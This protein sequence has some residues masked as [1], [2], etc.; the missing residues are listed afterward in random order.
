MHPRFIMT[1]L[2]AALAMTCNLAMAQE[3][4]GAKAP[5]FKPTRSCETVEDYDP[6]WNSHGDDYGL[7]P[8]STAKKKKRG[9]KT[10]E[11]QYVWGFYQMH[12]HDGVLHATF[13]G[14]SR[15]G[16]TPGALV[17][18]D[19]DTLR[20]QDAIRL[21]FAAHALSVDAGGK[22]AVVTHTAANAFSIIDLERGTSTCHK[23][24]T[25]LEGF[26]HRGRYVRLDEQGNFFINYND[27]S[28]RSSGSVVMKYTPDGEHASGFV[29]QVTGKD[30]VIPLAYLD[31][32]VLSG[33]KALKSVDPTSGAV[34]TLAELGEDANV[35][36][37]T[38]GPGKQV[39]ASDNNIA[40]RPNLVLI[41]PQKGTHTGLFTGIGTVEV[42]YVPEAG[43]VFTSNYNGQSVTV[44]ALPAD[45]SSFTPGQFV[46]IPFEGNPATL[47][48]RRS[49][50]GTDVYVS[51]KFWEK[52]NASRGAQISRIRIAP[53]VKGIDGID[54]P[55]ACTITTFDMK[56]R[57]V[58]AARPC[59][60]LDEK[61]SYRHTQ[62]A[63]QTALKQAK[64]YQTKNEQSLPKLR[65]DLHR[66]QQK[67]ARDPSDENRKA[68]DKLQEELAGQKSFA[69]FIARGLK[70][71]ETGLQEIEALMK[72]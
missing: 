11:R 44:A 43:Q 30:L 54:Q 61:A 1:P 14:L 26:D 49:E 70:D 28:G 16:V 63:I 35:Y 8:A 42:A 59:R 39:L 24:D 71:G 37:Y 22:R 47:A 69:Q 72:R 36:N 18:L 23:A 25:H 45:A 10:E 15:K 32:K 13:G 65:A 62:Q 53:S 52:D 64:G 55:G 2:A 31:G 21:P 12:V 58:S 33:S 56:D 27:F 17:K 68:A 67:A 34:D 6:Q 9:D 66:A 5:E 3:A 48:V 51:Q 4:T 60:I 50:Q 20:Y 38:A 29:P 46:N 7:T 19:A 40:A 41:D 57:S